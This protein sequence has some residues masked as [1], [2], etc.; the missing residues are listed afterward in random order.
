MPMPAKDIYHN[1]V[2]FA[3]VKDEWSILT[4]DYTLE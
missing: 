3:L 2:R 1:T 4:D